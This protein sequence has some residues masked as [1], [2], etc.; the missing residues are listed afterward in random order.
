MNQKGASLIIPILVIAIIAVGALVLFGKNNG[1][2]MPEVAK[3]TVQNSIAVGEQNPAQS[4]SVVPT[5]NPDE[6]IA[7]ISASLDE[8]TTV[9]D[10]SADADAVTSDTDAINSY[11]NAYDAT[12]F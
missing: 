3:K 7:A 11:A 6:T 12:N 8:E 10:A 1:G 2:T 5:G 4:K 9:A